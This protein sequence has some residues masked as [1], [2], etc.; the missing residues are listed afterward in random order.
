MAM[1]LTLTVAG[2]VGPDVVKVQ[3]NGVVATLTGSN[4]T[5]DVPVTSGVVSITAVNAAGVESVRT[6]QVVATS[7]AAG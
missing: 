7:S 3:V 2:V 1:A 5:A 6:L 4:Y